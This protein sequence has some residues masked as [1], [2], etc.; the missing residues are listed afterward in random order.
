M[1]ELAVFAAGFVAIFYAATIVI[2]LIAA[3]IFRNR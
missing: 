2:G 1:F 3:V